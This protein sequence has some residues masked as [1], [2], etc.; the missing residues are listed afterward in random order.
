MKPTPIHYFIFVRPPGSWTW[1]M[2]TNNAF[3][4]TP[5]RTG[6]IEKANKMAQSISEHSTYCAIVKGIEL[7]QEQDTEQY[8]IFADGETVYKPTEP[9]LSKRTK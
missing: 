3:S 1:T 7:P 4:G 9:H 2:H 8:A 6:D 5:W